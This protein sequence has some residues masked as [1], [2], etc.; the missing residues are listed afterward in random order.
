MMMEDFQETQAMNGDQHLQDLRQRINAK[1]ENLVKLRSTERRTKRWAN[2]VVLAVLLAIL[3]ALVVYSYIENNLWKFST[4]AC[5]FF[6]TALIADYILKMI[7]RRYLTRM[8]S[9]STA[10][11][12]YREVKRLITTHKLRLWIPLAAALACGSFVR[13]RPEPWLY[14]LL[15]DSGLVL[16]S[17]LGSKMR[18]WF[19]DDDFCYDVDEL[20]DLIAQESAA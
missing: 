20:G 13:N 14:S 11:Q 7:M 9:P 17:I 12:Y 5:I 3:V 6:A 2:I 4:W 16:G 10:P 8:K 19:L 1:A 18:N 15:F